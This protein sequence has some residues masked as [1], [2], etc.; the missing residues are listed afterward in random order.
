[1]R[2]GAESNGGDSVNISVREGSNF[3]V[4]YCLPSG[5]K[6]VRSGIGIFA[7]GTP[8]DQMT[9]DNANLIGFWLKTP[10]GQPGAA[11]GE[12]EAFASELT[13]G[14]QYQVLLFHDPQKG[15]PTAIGRT[16]A[17][18]VTPALPH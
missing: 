8:S 13:P 1:M 11:C 3:G 5:I 16:A 18:T 15:A 2:I 10:G 12:G 6:P 4:R 14:Q 17:F 9:K 7:A